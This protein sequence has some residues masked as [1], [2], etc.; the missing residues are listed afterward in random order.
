MNKKF[1]IIAMIL[2]QLLHASDVSNQ[3]LTSNSGTR[4]PWVV[5]RSQSS[6]DYN[7]RIDA[8]PRTHSDPVIDETRTIIVS[9]GFEEVTKRSFSLVQGAWRLFKQGK[10]EDNGEKLPGGKLEKSATSTPTP[11]TPVGPSSVNRADTPSTPVA[12]A[13]RTVTPSGAM[14]AIEIEEGE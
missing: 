5:T 7:H 11:S 8:R 6:P 2:P 14:F 10:T 4:L 12:R 1:F 13:I 9:T 3:S